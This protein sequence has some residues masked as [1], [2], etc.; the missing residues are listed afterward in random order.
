ML[1]I[2]NI[3]EIE[4]DCLQLKKEKQLTEYGKGQLDLIKI[5]KKDLSQKDKYTIDILKKYP[6]N[7]RTAVSNL[8]IANELHNL[9][10]IIEKKWNSP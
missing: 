5:I 2:Y 6:V 1:N 7:S 3:L 4:K 10:K 8:I 9:S